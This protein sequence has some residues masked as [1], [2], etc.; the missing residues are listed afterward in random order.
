[1]VFFN[2]DTSIKVNWQLPLKIFLQIGLH[3][4]EVFEKSLLVTWR[5]AGQTGGAFG[6]GLNFFNQEKENKRMNYLK[7]HKPQ[8]F[9]KCTDA[10]H[11]HNELL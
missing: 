8:A 10:L 7:L 2:F 4:K 6:F 11:L 1:M 9:Q 3:F 5:W